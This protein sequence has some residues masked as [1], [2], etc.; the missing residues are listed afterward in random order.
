MAKQKSQGSL[1]ANTAKVIYAVLENGESLRECLPQYQGSLSEQDKAWMQEMTFGV[2][3]KLPLLQHWLRQL[4]QKPLKGK[5]KVLEH[6]LMLGFYQLAFS[7]VPNHAA[8]SETVDATKSLGCVALKGLVNAVLR[9]FMREEMHNQISDEPHIQA[10]LPKWL[11]KRLQKNYAD[12]LPA[13]IEGITTRP[14]LWLRVNARKMT[15]EDYLAKLQEEGFTENNPASLPDTHT[16]ALILAKSTNVQALPGYEE[17]WFSVQDGAAQLAAQYL[18]A[19]AGD[20]VLDACCAPGGKTCHILESQPG[21]S[22][23]IAI[24]NDEYRLKRV[25]ENLSR[26]QLSA[27]VKCADVAETSQ[28]W[29]GKPFD[30]IL[31]DAPCSATGVIRRHPDILWLRKSSD[32]EALTNIQKTILDALWQTLKPGGVMI[33]ATCSILAEENQEQIRQF[34]QRTTDAKL[35]PLHGNDSEANPGRQ[36]LPGEQQMDG[37]YYA[38]LLKS[39]E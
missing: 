16:Q 31:L 25:H 1:R 3:R 38:R 8:V 23:C 18:D 2:L 28:W 13:I 33:Y 39:I 6:L 11:F 22:E 21:L 26:L 19:Q 17:G 7:R 29:D 10:G 4:L 35:L 5:N 12:Q 27:H 32:I 36:I 15:R 9:N 30:R 37:F 34:L 20:T 24:D 14:P